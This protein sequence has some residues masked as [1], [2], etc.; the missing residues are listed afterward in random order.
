MKGYKVKI[1]LVKSSDLIRLILCRACSQ[2]KPYF[3]S[4]EELYLVR[5]NLGIC[6]CKIVVYRYPVDFYGKTKVRSKQI[7]QKKFNFLR[8]IN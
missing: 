1:K 6:K 5:Y 3:V 2:N 8:I 4:H 7:L